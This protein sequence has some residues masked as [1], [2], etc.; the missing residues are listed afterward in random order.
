MNSVRAAALAAAAL[1]IV[2]PAVHADVRTRERT[3][4]KFEGFL[5]GVM[6]RAMGGA[7]GITSTVALKGNRMARLSDTSGQIVDLDEGRVYSLD[8]RRKEYTVMTFEQ[9]RQQMAQAREQL[10][11][12]SQ[13]MTPEQKQA[14]D[15]AAAEMQY[16]VDVRE[17]GQRRPVAGHD[18]REVVLTI[19]MHQQGKTVEE[20]GGIVLT[21]SIW[22]APRVPEMDEMREFTIRMYKAMFASEFS[23][24][25]AQQ[26]NA[27]GVMLPGIGQLSERMAVEA[28]T[29]QGTPLS[30]TMTFE[31]VR[32]AA[33]IQAASANEPP[34]SGGIGGALAARLMRGRG[35][36]PQQRTVTAT[37]SND[38]LSI[39]PAAGDADVAMPPGFKEKR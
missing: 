30:S 32:S 2:A 13:Q 24:I 31:T 7:D 34:P 4:V 19:A 27:L 37:I 36:P 6:N 17:T 1:W 22:L 15:Q 14:L 8:M 11:K 9:M 25:D 38:T 12:Q 18:A 39:A 29:L 35:G 16:D 10:A 26:L 23:G 21:S 28:R 3:V 33:Q 5:G 20:S